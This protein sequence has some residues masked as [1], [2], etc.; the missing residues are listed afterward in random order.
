MEGE[1]DH[2]RAEGQNYPERVQGKKDPGWEEKR[3][4]GWMEGWKDLEW[5][6]GWEDPVRVEGEENS[7]EERRMGMM[8]GRTSLEAKK[9]GCYPP[10]PHHRLVEKQGVCQTP[11]GATH[12][13]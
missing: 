11:R 8:T 13:L 4:H 7:S 6:G 12:R 5:V 1:K 9:N 2:R 10:R 3:D